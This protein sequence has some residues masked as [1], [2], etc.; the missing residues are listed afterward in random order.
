M[1]LSIP[2]TPASEPQP[3]EKQP[4]TTPIL[5]K[6]DIEETAFNQLI[7]DDGDGQS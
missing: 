1:N 3:A 2:S 7:T 6:M 4:W 5:K